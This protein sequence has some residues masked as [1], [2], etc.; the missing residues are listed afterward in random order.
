VDHLCSQNVKDFFE[1]GALLTEKRLKG[2]FVCKTTT[3]TMHHIVQP[4]YF[5]ALLPI[6]TALVSL[7]S[8]QDG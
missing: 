3:P 4:H 5:L 2:A 6:T 8:K 1:F 7:A